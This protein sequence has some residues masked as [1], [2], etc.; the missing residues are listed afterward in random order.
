M[1]IQ[2]AT[3][4]RL[5]AKL[6]PI[7]GERLT[8]SYNPTE[9]TFNKGVQYAE[10]GIPGLDMPIQQFV[11]GQTETLTF[12][13][14]FD[15]TESGMGTGGGVTA[16]TT[17]TDQFY[18]LIKIDPDTKAPPICFFSWGE[19]GFPGS[20]LAGPWARQ[21][22]ENGFQCLVESINQKFTLFSPLGVPLRA[23]ITV[24]L[25]EYQTLAQQI[26]AIDTKIYVAQ[27]GD[28][29]EQIAEKQYGKSDDWRAIAEHNNIDDPSSIPPGTTLEIPPR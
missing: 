6:K 9:I 23:T 29:L 19:K 15:T 17:R 1:S 16:V 24:K 5:D 8:V 7:P 2:K 4:Q 18:E 11:R 12:D 13:L 10:I 26:A 21:R 14:F 20:N 27:E 28:T 22:R 3:I 25:R